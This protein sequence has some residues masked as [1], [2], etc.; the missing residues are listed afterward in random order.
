MEL[1]VFLPGHW[2]DLSRAPGQLYAE[3][4]EQAVLAETLGFHTAWLAEHHFNNYVA[5]P[6]PL[7]LAAIIADRTSKIRIGVAVV[8]APF[9]HPLRLAGELA[10]LDVLANGRLDV[11]IG[12]G[13]FPWEAQQ[14]G[15]HQSDDENRATCKE[16]LLVMAKTLRSRMRS[17]DHEGSHWSFSNVTIIPPTATSSSPRFWVAAQSPDSVPW[18]VAA[19]LDAG[20]PPVIFC[21]L[22]RRPFTLVT[23]MRDAISAVVAR[24]AWSERPQLGINHMVHVAPSAGQARAEAVAALRPLNRAIYNLRAAGAG[25]V[26]FIRDGLATVTPLPR[27][28]SDDELLANT[29]IGDAAFALEQVARFERHGVN[30]LS[31]HF[32]FGQPHEVVVRSMRM[33]A[34]AIGQRHGPAEPSAQCRTGGN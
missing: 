19:C 34:Q 18:A 2:F 20:L 7:Q 5:Q 33:F 29:M 27:E 1:G 11:A 32:N 31:L 25:S 23:E 21:S 12:R 6:G 17:V 15:I 22:L 10:Q 8:V 14:M 26:Q 4:I 13:A 16:H 30:H 24:R 9:H 28:P 3:L